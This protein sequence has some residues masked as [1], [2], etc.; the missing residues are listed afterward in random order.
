MIA[1]YSTVSFS[2]TSCTSSLFSEQPQRDRHIYQVIGVL[3]NIIINWKKQS[4]SKPHTSSR[5]LNMLLL[6]R[7]CNAAGALSQCRKQPV[8]HSKRTCTYSHVNMNHPRL[9]TLNKFSPSWLCRDAARERSESSPEIRMK[10]LQRALQDAVKAED[11]TTA[12][13]LKIELQK[14][15]ETST[16]AASELDLLRIDL[17]AA[18]TDERYKVWRLWFDG[19]CV[20]SK[21]VHVQL[22]KLACYLFQLFCMTACNNMLFCRF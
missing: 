21:C 2:L 3:E 4:A 11:Y 13:R 20:K 6:C 15:V 19:R 14:L 16:P 18:I 7:G 8:L 22:L 5:L 17:K 1:S 9:T 10:A 12:G